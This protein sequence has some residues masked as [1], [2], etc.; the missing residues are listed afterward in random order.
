MKKMMEEKIFSSKKNTLLFIGGIV[1][2][3][4]LIYQIILSVRGTYFSGSSDDVVQYEPILR[5]YI[6]YFKDG[7]FSF[8]NFSNNTGSSFFAD[9]YYLPIDIFTIITLLLGLVVDNYIAFSI[10]NLFKVFLGVVV[11]AYFLQKSRYNNK[12]VT[13]LSLIYFAVGGCWV[14]TVFSTYFSMFFYLPLSLLFVY[15][16]CNGKKWAMPLYCVSL[17]FYNFYNAYTL[18]IFM[19]FAYIVVRIRDCYTSLKNLFKD[20]IIFGLHIILG[21]FM[22]LIVLLPSALYIL[23]YSVRDIV[24][25]QVLFDLEIYLKMLYK[26]F[27]YESGVD[28]LVIAMHGDNSYMQNH[29]SLY[30]GSFNL[31]ILGILFF[32]KDRTSRIYKWTLGIILCMMLIPVFSMIFSGVAVAYTR[33]FSFIN[34]V[35]IY[36]LGHVLENMKSVEGLDRKERIIIFSLLGIYLISFISGVVMMVVESGEGSLNSSLYQ[37][38]MLVIFAVFVLLYLIFYFSKQRELVIGVAVLELIVA[39]MINFYHPLVDYSAVQINE[40]EDDYNELFTKLD[41]DSDSLQRVYLSNKLTNSSRYTGVLTSEKTFHSFMSEW[42]YAFYSLYSKSGALPVYVETLNRYSPN[43]SRVLDYKYIVLDKDKDFGY[44]LDYFKLYYEDENYLV[45]ENLNYSPFYVYENYIDEKAIIE[46][47][48]IN[49]LDLEKNLF[50]GVILEDGDKYSL[51]E[52]EFL[53]DSSVKR[54]DFSKKLNLS[55]SE[56][57]F[58]VADLTFLNNIKGEEKTIYVNGENV[59]SNVKNM[60]LEIDGDKKEC[61][62]YKSNYKCK[63]SG[64]IE[65]IVVESDEYLD[66]SYTT[67]IE[68]EEN[69]FAYIEAPVFENENIIYVTSNENKITLLD[70]KDNLR[71]CLYG[72]CSVGDKDVEYIVLDVSSVEFGEDT[73]L[74][75]DYIDDDLEYYKNNSKDLY[76]SDKELIQKGSSLR[77]KYHRLTNNDNNQVIVL[78]VTYSYEWICD[79]NYELVRVNGGYLGIVVDKGVENIDVLITFKPK[80]V[81]MGCIGSLIGIG[82]YGIYIAIII[83]RNRRKTYEGV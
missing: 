55:L 9:I 48:T 73:E 41:I 82:V 51:N 3:V 5:Q 66:L 49:L 14:Y 16:Y 23:N 58:Y 61:S 21:V 6:E 36:F 4:L 75:V 29:F 34:I 26:L 65:R 63:F 19:L 59:I 11:F 50:A 56:E 68:E 40:M 10:A 77:V 22:G 83:I 44:E 57:R 64:E 32:M 28:A 35:L 37:I 27:V 33:W 76:A 54:I 15:Y 45:Y 7:N 72:I 70:S 53:K 78:P 38:A 79:N 20:V 25:F 13:I 74:Y 24:N 46:S 67:I 12:T 1:F 30:I 17:I 52:V 80:G 71:E 8:F 60:W 42:V 18:F 39:L 31:F 2:F 81:K 43:Y 62:A 47:E 69:W